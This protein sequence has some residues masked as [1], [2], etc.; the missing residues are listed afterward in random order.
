MFYNC[1][2]IFPSH[3][4]VCNSMFLS[5][6]F[7]SFSY[8]SIHLLLYQIDPLPLFNWTNVALE[9]LCCIAARNREMS[10][11][12]MIRRNA[13]T[14]WIFLHQTDNRFLKQ[15]WKPPSIYK[16]FC[17]IDIEYF[18]YDTQTCRMKF[19][20]WTYNGFLLDVRQL[21]VRNKKNGKIL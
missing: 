11:E 8:C 21:P 14:S 15:V 7:H 6:F 3:Q 18:P 9:N 13:K 2:S 10:R 20:G 1:F 4:N 5:H 12:M 19:G 16:S 17:S